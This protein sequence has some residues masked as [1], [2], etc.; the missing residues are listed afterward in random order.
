M[1]QRVVAAGPGAGKS[2]IFCPGSKLSRGSI[3]R[4]LF[5]ITKYCLTSQ[6]LSIIP[7]RFGSFAKQ[8]SVQWSGFELSGRQRFCW[9]LSDSGSP[10]A[11]LPRKAAELSKSNGALSA[12]PR[13]GEVSWCRA[14]R[15]PESARLIFYSM[16]A[17]V[18]HSRLV[19]VLKTA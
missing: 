15:P 10:R 5:Y 16:S 11:I 9:P 8:G 7:C 12:G 4:D 19:A 17:E 3:A 13:G 6:V 2:E 14:G 18:I 1:L